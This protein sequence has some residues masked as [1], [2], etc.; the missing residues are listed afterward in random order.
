MAVTIDVVYGGPDLVA[1]AEATGLTVGQVVERHL[2]GT[3]TVAFCG[4]SP[5][6]AY[7]RGLDPALQIPR[8]AVPRTRVPAGSVAIAARY[9]SVYPSASPGGWVNFVDVTNDEN[10]ISVVAR[11]IVRSHPIPKR[12][13]L[14]SV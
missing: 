12:G 11:L 14:S 13:N 3:Y 2:S 5:G 9:S 7:L 6:F 4:F 10:F 8:R 1:V